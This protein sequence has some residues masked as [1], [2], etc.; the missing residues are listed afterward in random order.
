MEHQ[1]GPDRRF[2]AALRLTAELG[3]ARIAGFV[4][5]AERAPLLDCCQR[6]AYEPQPEVVGLVRQEMELCAL[7]P[8]DLEGR[9]LA[10]LRSLL[11]R[12]LAAVR[13]TA[14]EPGFRWL[15]GLAPNEVYVQR[16]RAGSAGITSHRDR[17]TFVRLIGIV[18][19]GAPVTF[20]TS[21]QREGP[22]L[23]R[24]P[25]ESGDLVLLRGHGFGKRPDR[26]PF[27]AVSG[28]ESGV[29]YS[30]TFRMNRKAPRAALP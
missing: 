6:L 26:R 8:E 17:K 14:A 22:P 16:Y 18:S 10:P 2:A 15:A 4:P 13:R 12:Y 23:T 24:F 1:D 9:G 27:H 20:Q 3:A 25:V 29:R 7:R 28:P 21:L 11:E 19:L 30:V 5:E